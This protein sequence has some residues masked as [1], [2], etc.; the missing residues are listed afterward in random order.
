MK[1]SFY[2]LTVSLLVLCVLIGGALAQWVFSGSA[3]PAEAEN[4]VDI[5]PFYYKPQEVLPDEDESADLQENHM[6]LLMKILNDN[7]YGL[8]YSN[9]LD[10]AVNLHQLLRSQENI[11]GGN[12]KHLFTTNESKLLDFTIEYVSDSKYILYTYEDD[13]LASGALN[14]TRITVFKI[15]LA[16]TNGKWDAEGAVEGHSIIRQF[17]TSNNKTYRTIH[18]DDFIAGSLASYQA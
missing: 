6:D 15:V 10:N 5:N 4:G 9:T 11:S 16:Y 1:R 12:L 13:D 3:N 14:D 17:K 2:F 7:K 8:N 18:P